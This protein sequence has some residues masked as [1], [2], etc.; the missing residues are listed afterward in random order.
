MTTQSID[1]GV[2]VTVDARTYH[3]IDPSTGTL[4]RQ[5]P[6]LLDA[7][8]ED[9][10]ARAH[11][12]F[13]GWRDTSVVERVRLFRRFADLVDRDGDKLAYQITVEMGKALA[14]S[15]DEVALVAHLFRY[16]ADNG[17]E[18]LRDETLDVP[19]LQQT[20]IRREPVGVVLGIEPW[21]G[22]I[23]QAMRAAVPNLMLGNTVLV[24]PAEQ[25]PGSTLMLDDLFVEAGFPADVYQTVLVSVDHVSTYIA[26]SRVRAVTFTGSDR[27]GAV[28]GAQAGAHVKPVVLELGGSDAFIVLDSADV[29]TAAA[30][31]SAC[32]IYMGGQACVSPKRIILTDKIADEFI[33]QFASAFGSQT[34][35]NPF[36][37][38]TTIGPMASIA[39]AD[40]VQAQLQDAIDKGATV[41]V[42]GG[43]MPGP[44]AYFRP[45]AIAGVTSE[46]RVATEEVFG[47]VALIYR[48]PDADAAIEVANSSKYGLGGTVF[49]LD[50]EEAQHVAH[51][52]DTGMVGIN[53]YVGAPVEIP[54]GGT[55]ASG[56][57]RELGRSGMDQFANIKTYGIG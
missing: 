52:L 45:A 30:V 15:V 3:T 35:G 18:L 5:Y 57:G 4:V 49:G 27:A 53:G 33:A 20:I 56:T 12:A 8:A 7:H 38:A 48:V 14:Q 36:D 42:P 17:E 2:A 19:G 29:P 1:G 11:K 46:M 43:R 32:R 54:F 51:R 9:H 26:D 6:K 47:P 23:F 13:P 24:K 41:V 44:G 40:R 22:P 16:Y 39:A 34:V 31:A 25:C 21:N 10:L 55:K 28:I 37:P 50:L